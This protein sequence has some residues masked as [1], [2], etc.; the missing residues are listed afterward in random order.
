MS[1]PPP[2]TLPTSP[3]PP[4]RSAA[5]GACTLRTAPPA[6]CTSAG[7]CTRPMAVPAAATRPGA[8]TPP[9][10]T[11]AASVR[12]GEE[13]AAIP[14]AAEALASTT[15]RLRTRHSWTIVWSWRRLR[16][17]SIRGGRCAKPRGG[18]CLASQRQSSLPGS[19]GPLPT[20]GAEGCKRRGTG[21]PRQPPV[22]TPRRSSPCCR[23]WGPQHLQRWLSSHGG[24]TT[25]VKVSGGN[26][27]ED[28]RGPP[29]PRQTTSSSSPT[30]RRR[31]VST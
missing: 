29:G 21:S 2:W 15:C 14:S 22:S 10:A 24:S 4:Q 27:G 26:R 13:A 31:A 20:R 23:T 8:S 7:A 9:A 18:R 11:P 28:R 5:E 17:T 19:R 25:E 12:P 16:R 1:R 30:R 6:S 3:R